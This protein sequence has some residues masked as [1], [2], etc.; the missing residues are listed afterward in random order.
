MEFEI[1]R[2]KNPWTN[3][4]PI[5]AFPPWSMLISSRQIKKKPSIFWHIYSYMISNLSES[6]PNK[7]PRNPHSFS[8]SPGGSPG[9]TFWPKIGSLGI[10]HVLPLL[11]TEDPERWRTTLVAMERMEG[12][13]TPQIYLIGGFNPKNMSS[14][15]WII[16]LTIENKIH[17]PKQQSYIYIY[18]SQ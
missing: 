7:S 18:M 10:F 15:D 12:G 13:K 14:S 5:W 16:I 3:D 17:V 1:P 6:M 9:L 2:W 11:C 8:G 4:Q